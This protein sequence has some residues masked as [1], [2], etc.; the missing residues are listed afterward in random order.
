[1]TP[2]DIDRLADAIADRLASLLASADDPVGDS[3]AAAEWIA[4]SVPTIERMV[5]DGRI[6]SFTVG[7]LRRF[8]RS[9]VLAAMKADGGEQ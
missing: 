1:M 3:H 7:R 2:N 5:R 8:R 9:E 6:P 4:C